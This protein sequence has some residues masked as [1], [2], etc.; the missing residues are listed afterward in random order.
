MKLCILVDGPI[1]S[2]FTEG[3]S[4]FDTST[5][6]IVAAMSLIVVVMILQGR[7]GFRSGYSTLSFFNFVF[8]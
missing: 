8:N 6:M 2:L 7:H 5:I 4:R 3:P 1:I